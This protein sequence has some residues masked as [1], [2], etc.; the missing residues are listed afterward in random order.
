VILRA[1][2]AVLGG[3]AATAAHAGQQAAEPQ[4][5]QT[6]IAQTKIA[7]KIVQYQETPKGDQKCSICVNFDP[8]NACKIVEGTISPE[9]WCIAFGPKQS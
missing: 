5:A 9:G 4:T 7:Q 1:G 8:P 2:L 6:K 3:A